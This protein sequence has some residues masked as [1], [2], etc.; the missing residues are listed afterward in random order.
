MVNILHTDE[1]ITD[2]ERSDILSEK[3]IWNQEHGNS[4]PYVVDFLNTI[5]RSP[6]GRSFG[7]TNHLLGREEGI[8]GFSGEGLIQ[9]TFDRELTEKV[10]ALAKNTLSELAWKNVND[11]GIIVAERGNLTTTPSP[12]KGE[13]V[14]G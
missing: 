9:T 5:P 10:D 14:S 2:M 4:L 7:E 12:S 11:Y 8:D 13:V 3:F 1:T 6:R